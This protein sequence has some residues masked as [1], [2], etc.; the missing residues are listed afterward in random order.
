MCN[1]C[2]CVQWAIEAVRP[3]I[4]NVRSFEHWL[5]GSSVDIRQF[6]NLISNVSYHCPSACDFRMA[7]NEGQVQYSIA[8][9]SIVQYFTILYSRILLSERAC[10]ACLPSCTRLFKQPSASKDHMSRG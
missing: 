5:I 1:T 4:R 8:S 2:R 10:F 9:S 6:G 3:H 7:E